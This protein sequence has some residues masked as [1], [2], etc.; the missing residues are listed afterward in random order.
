LIG[1]QQFA[2]SAAAGGGS[3]RLFDPDQTERFA[4]FP[5]PG[6]VGE[7][8]TA[9]ADFNADGV[10]DLV[11]A[12]GP[13]G[14]PRVVVLDGQ[15][16]TELFLIE[17]FES[18][19]VGGVF[20][21]AGDID[22]DGLADLVVT[23]DEGGG[24]RV[25]VFRGGDFGQVADFFGINDPNFRGGARAA[26]GDVNGDGTGDLIVSAGFSG[27][28][29]VA[30]YDGPTVVEG[31]PAP[32]FADFF[33][34]ELTLRNGVYLTA[35]DLD[36]DGFAEVI[37]GGGPGGGPRVSAFDGRMLV[38]GGSAERV[39]DFFAGNAGNRGGVRVAIKNLDGDA[40]AD[41][42][43]GSG[44]GAGSRV[45]AYLGKDLDLPNTRPEVFGFDAFPGFTE[46]VFV[47]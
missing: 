21:A 7:V 27:G 11:A 3:V 45:T 36:G 19:F 26:V 25:R 34:F 28:P 10:A 31:V 16:R 13:G 14:S 20:V 30:G 29:R 43:T 42:V 9:A 17:P 4:A 35:G 39:M 22:G 5:F 46:G 44:T 23:P 41:L 18:T 12:T 6:F 2:A 38:A 15:S 47:G 40:R 32:L 33:A 37:A 8:R 1:F 24:P